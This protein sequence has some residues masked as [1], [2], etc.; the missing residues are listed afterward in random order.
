MSQLNDLTYLR[1]REAQCRELAEK[2]FDP[3]V[4]R[5]HR[6]FADR[7]ARDALALEEYLASARRATN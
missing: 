1:R 3:G 2:A 6:D 5:L 4:K 7:Y